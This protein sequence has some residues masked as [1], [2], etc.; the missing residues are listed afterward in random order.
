E[1][2]PF[3]MNQDGRVIDTSTEMT[4]SL[5]KIFGKKVGSSLLR[6]IFLTDKYSDSAK[7]MADDVKAMGTSTAVANTNY[8]KTD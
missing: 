8:I 5:N 2:I 7:E 6:N 4:R 1:P 3:L